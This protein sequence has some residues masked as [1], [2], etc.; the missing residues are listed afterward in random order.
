[1]KPERFPPARMG[2]FH[3]LTIII[4]AVNLLGSSAVVSAQIPTPTP[5]ETPQQ[6]IDE[7]LR[8]S[9]E[10]PAWSLEY[11]LAQPDDQ[12]DLAGRALNAREQLEEMLFSKQLDQRGVTYRVDEPAPEDFKV[13]LNGQSSLD[14]LRGLL[15]GELAPELDFL[16]G[17]IVIEITG[18]ALDAQEIPVWLESRPATGYSWALDQ[19]GSTMVEQA[20]L[21]TVTPR[22]EIAGAAALAHLTL[23]TTGAGESIVRL[24]YRRPWLPDEPPVRVI[25]LQYTTLPGQIDLSSPVPLA[26]PEAPV[27]DAPAVVEPMAALPASF[28]WRA[29]G[30][31][32]PI[33]DQ[34]SCGSCWAF[35]T[36]GAME[37]AM[38]VQ[39]GTAADLSEQYLVSCNKIGYDC[40]GGWWAHDYHVSTPGK[41]QSDSGAVLETTKPYT[42]SNGTCSAAY[43]HPY[44]AISWGYVSGSLS[45]MPSVDQIKNAIYTYGGVVASVCSGNAW[46]GYTGG[47]FSTEERLQCKGNGQV[48]HAILL[49]GWN[50][51]NQTWILKN[52]WGSWWG[53]QGYMYIKYGT[54]KV[55][56]GASYVTY[57]SPEAPSNDAI[58]AAEDVGTHH[59]GP[60]NYTDSALT[61]VATVEPTDPVFPYTSNPRKGA[62]T[63]W[64]RFTPVSNGTL[65]INTSGSSYDTILGV[66]TGQPDALVLVKWND[67]NGSSKQSRVSFT[68][69]KGVPYYIEVAAANGGGQMKLNLTYTPAAP[70]N[71]SINSAVVIPYA[72]DTQPGSYT[73]VLDVYQTSVVSSD[74]VF[75]DGRGRGYR[76]VWYKFSPKVN[77]TLTLSTAGSNYATLLGAWRKTST[78]RLLGMSD[79]GNLQI[80]VVGGMVYYVE[81][82]SISASGPS[83]LN[84]RADFAPVTAVGVGKF[85]NL[86]SNIYRIGVWTET[87]AL[88]TSSTI[89][90]AVGLTFTG[91]RVT[92]QF[93]RQPGAGVLGIYIDGKSAAS[94]K[95]S[96]TT[97]QEQL[98]WSSAVL[99][100]GTH[101]LSLIHSSGGVVNFDSVQVHA[102]ASSAAAGSYDDDRH[103]VIFYRGIWQAD[104]N[105][106]GAFN[107]TQMRSLGSGQKATLTFNGSGLTLRYARLPG[108]GTLKVYVDGVLLGSINQAA[109]VPAYQM[110][111]TSKVLANKQHTLTLQHAA[112]AQVN[113]DAIE[114][115]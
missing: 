91:Q 109:A 74:P 22:T 90:D 42:A 56:Y 47:V 80:Q 55:G 98:Q 100:A 58:A 89:S 70:A 38:L 76:T 84:L 82:A 106:N 103:D 32:T 35:G 26:Q 1:M 87:G 86:N 64:Y 44:K 95:Q 112:G 63:V 77:G 61:S 36:V 34:G 85:D 111:W 81:I 101:T 17:V 73:S 66:W 71:N 92:V 43:N 31:V 102:A 30:K 65:T 105:V 69:G 14:S 108:A 83:A 60:V 2:V 20:S 54:S 8:A 40:D 57:T 49:V 28:D 93:S 88:S 5:E 13:S 33:R 78:F 18:A 16:G 94:I 23:R 75:P 110:T 104:T 24:V 41:N 79:N 46:G 68:T 39:G 113:I 10:L 29:Q 99:A 21:S 45:V 6:P 107:G 59:G 67:N 27:L 50:D 114:I 51:A 15:F 97:A 25:R 48:N 3:L 72:G 37:S 11:V 62:N 9:D 115:R 19:A 53:D 7:Q 12:S 52:S 96:A 4:V